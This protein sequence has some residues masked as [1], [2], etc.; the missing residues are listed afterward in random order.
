MNGSTWT[1]PPIDYSCTTPRVRGPIS[2][3]LSG[4]HWS[5]GRTSGPRRRTSRSG[6]VGW[7][8]RRGRGP[9]YL[10]KKVTTS[11]TT[12]TTRRRWNAR[13]RRWRWPR[14]GNGSGGR[15]PSRG[16]SDS[17]LKT[18]RSGWR[19]GT[20]TRTS[21]AWRRPSRLTSSTRLIA[22]RWSHEIRRLR[23]RTRRREPPR[24]LRTWRDG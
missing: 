3:W 12:T 4:R 11:T 1:K 7:R 19:A 22:A 5:S 24:R 13:G 21:V 15:T 16:R 10:R 17:Y 9:S 2:T 23:H 6:R 14:S 20:R 8:R 18:R